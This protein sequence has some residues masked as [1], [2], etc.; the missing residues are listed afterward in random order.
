MINENALLLIAHGSRRDRSNTEIREL[1]ER[2]RTR[3]EHFS[4]VECAF[5][6]LAEPSIP[7]ALR[8][9][10]AAGFNE[11]TVLPYFLS[12]GRHVVEDI[13][14]EISVVAREY[15]AVRIRQAPYLGDAEGV[16]DLLLRQAVL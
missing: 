1:T 8:G 16:V 5:L 7:H 4:R 12:R 3:S 14:A 6:E 11:I 10:V 13:P 15:P 9:L 2:L